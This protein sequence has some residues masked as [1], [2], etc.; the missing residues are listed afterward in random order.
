MNVKA[1]GPCRLFPY[2]LIRQKAA[3]KKVIIV[4]LY[5]ISYVLDHFKGPFTLNNMYLYHMLL[6]SMGTHTLYMQC[7]VNGIPGSAW[8]SA[9][10][11]GLT[12]NSH[13]KYAAQGCASAWGGGSWGCSCKGALQA[14]HIC[15]K[16]LPSIAAHTPSW[17]STPVRNI[18]MIISKLTILY[19]SSALS[20]NGPLRI[21]GLKSFTA[22]RVV[23][24]R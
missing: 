3:I 16:H 17:G 15:T 11:L 23:L 1:E 8:P 14:M 22:M 12:M 13:S 19:Q 20:V 9:A 21:W 5:Y 24:V 2:R 6:Q 10:L 18:Y 4:L 7:T